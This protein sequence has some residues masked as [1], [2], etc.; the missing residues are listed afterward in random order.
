M[1]LFNPETLQFINFRNKFGVAGS[2]SGNFIKSFVE[3]PEHKLWI[4]TEG[5]GISIL[6]L[7]TLNDEI[8]PEKVF[9]EHIGE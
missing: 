3:T 6:D 4:G 2:I 5:N 8:N 1:A 9:F 7:N